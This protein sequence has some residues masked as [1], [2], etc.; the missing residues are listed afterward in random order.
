MAKTTA[1]VMMAAKKLDHTGMVTHGLA[2]PYC[3]LGTMVREGR[4]AANS[5]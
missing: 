3:G 1:I 4:V 5:R 2:E